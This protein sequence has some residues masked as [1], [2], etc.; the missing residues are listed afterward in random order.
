M[1]VSEIK[2]NS[3]NGITLISLVVTIVVL[4][5]LTIVTIKIITDLKIVDK[6]VNGTSDYISKQEEEIKEADNTTNFINDSVNKINEVSKVEE[7]F[8]EISNIK[9][10]EMTITIENPSEGDSEEYSIFMNGEI[11]KTGNQVEYIIDGL[12]AQTEYEIK[13]EGNNG[14]QKRASN[15]VKEATKKEFIFSKEYLN[16]GKTNGNVS[17][18]NDGI[19]SITGRPNISYTQTNASNIY[20]W[21]NEIDLT[22]Y[23]TLIVSAVKT[24]NHGSF[25][26]YI[27]GSFLT[28]RDYTNLDTNWHTYEVNISNYTGIH[29]V[30]FAGGYWD[31]S[32]N[33][34]SNTQYKDIYLTNK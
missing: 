18:T 16:S 3:R 32:G 19:I 20:R 27:D 30:A 26:I 12:N 21:Y 10:H 17:I 33:T 5:I 31:M 24:V 6:V 4:I 23:N 22:D 34:S 11:K 14:E 2:F 15:V 9:S 13:I 28:G 1:R 25:R 7:I 29:T 8:F